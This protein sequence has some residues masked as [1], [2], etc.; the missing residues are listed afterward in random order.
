MVIS[1]TDIVKSLQKKEKKKKKGQ[2]FNKI[3]RFIYSSSGYD[4]TFLGTRYTY[5]YLGS[6]LASWIIGDVFTDTAARIF[7]SI[8]IG[9]TA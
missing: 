7:C 8:A 6:V 1:P 3:F 5:L 2:L 9:R 4:M